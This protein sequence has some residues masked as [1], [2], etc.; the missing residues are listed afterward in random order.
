MFVFEEN[1]TFDWP[2]TVRY[3]TESGSDERSFTATFKLP[4]DELDLFDGTDAD[5][6]AQMI[7]D[8][9]DRVSRYWI[10]WS[11]IQTP[12]GTEL[13]FSEDTRARLLKQRPVREAIDRALA[14]AVL[15]IRE[16]N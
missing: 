11:G 14:E 8:A 6:L 2:V 10:G 15:G 3:P 12:D 4:D 16:K 13:A 5:S 1:Y 7:H 9:R